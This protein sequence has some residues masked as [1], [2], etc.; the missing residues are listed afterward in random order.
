MF[1]S[2]AGS[3]Y[4]TTRPDHPE[5]AIDALTLL[6]EDHCEVLALLEELEGQLPDGAADERR[7][8]SDSSLSW[9]RCAT[10]SAA[11]AKVS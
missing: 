9:T 8:G 1:A 4:G 5:A 11:E 7:T 2:A 3:G 10:R 6:R